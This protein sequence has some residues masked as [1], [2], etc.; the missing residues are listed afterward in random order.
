M[1]IIV[2]ETVCFKTE[3]HS[4]TAQKPKEC[5]LSQCCVTPPGYGEE[6]FLVTLSPF[7]S[8]SLITPISALSSCGLLFP[9]DL[10]GRAAI[11]F[12]IHLIQGELLFTQ[13]SAQAGFSCL[14]TTHSTAPRV[15]TDMFVGMEYNG[16][17]NGCSLHNYIKGS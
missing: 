10:P 9:E 15:R 4:L 2:S 13:L 7:L 8:Y 11:T 1:A 16:A 14:R 6:A 17:H 12:T 3:I 5:K